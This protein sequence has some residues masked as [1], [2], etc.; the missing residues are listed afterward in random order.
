MLDTIYLGINY[1]YLLGI[2]KTVQMIIYISRIIKKHG[3]I[4]NIII[5]I[6]HL[7]INKILALNNQ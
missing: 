5:S 3:T 6:K 1:L 4:E 2:L 7:Q